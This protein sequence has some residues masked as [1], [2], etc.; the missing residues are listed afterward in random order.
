MGDRVECL[1]EAHKAHIEWL[2]VLACLV[3][4]YS[5]IRDFISCPLPCWNPAYSSAISVSVVTRI[6]SNMIRRRILLAW[7]TR[8]T[9]LQ[10]ALFKIAFLGKWDERG[11]RSFLWPV[12]SFPDCHIFCA[13][14]PVPS[15]LL[16]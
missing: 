14:C 5:K 4:Q 16:L 10:F 12:T 11:E 2:L 9:V 7:E 6:L 3:Y 15:L 1:L 8:A 13:F